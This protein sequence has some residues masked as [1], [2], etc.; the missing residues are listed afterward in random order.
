MAMLTRAMPR[1]VARRMFATMS[2]EEVWASGLLGFWAPMAREDSPQEGK[3][4]EYIYVPALSCK[5]P[6]PA[7]GILPQAPF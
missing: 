2:R 6:P 5:G 4:R 7:H 1:G 3:C